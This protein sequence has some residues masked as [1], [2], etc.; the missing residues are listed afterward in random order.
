VPV[1][2]VMKRVAMKKLR[3]DDASANPPAAELPR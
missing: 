2:V 3:R 1:Y